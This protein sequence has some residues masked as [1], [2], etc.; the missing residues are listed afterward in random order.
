MPTFHP[1]AILRHPDPERAEAMRA[2]L[3]RHLRLTRRLAVPGA[4]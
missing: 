2:D 3:V 1:S 4:K